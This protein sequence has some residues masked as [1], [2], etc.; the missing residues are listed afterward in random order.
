M[1]LNNNLN[2]NTSNHCELTNIKLKTMKLFKGI[3]LFS[4]LFNVEYLLAQPTIT[5]FLPI[6]G[7]VGDTITISGTNFNSTTANNIVFFGATRAKVTTANTTSLTVTVPIGAMYAPITILDSATGLSANSTQ[8][9]NLTFSPNKGSFG[10]LDVAPHSDFSGGYLLNNID[11]GD[12]NGDGRPDVVCVNINSNLISVLTNTSNSGLVSF[13]T[14]IEFTTSAGPINVKCGDLDGDGKLDLAVVNY[15]T[16]IVSVYR[17]ISSNGIINFATMVNFT[18]G[19]SPRSV[20]I[21]DINGDGKLDLS[22]ANFGSN[23]VSVLRN[24]S[25]IGSISFATKVDFAT[26]SGPYSIA[27]GDIDGNG[28]PDLAVTNDYDSSVSVLRNTSSTTAITF[29]TRVNFATGLYPEFVTV[30]DLNG[31]NK[32]DMAVANCSNSNSVSILR[33]TSSSGTISFAGKVDFTMTSFPNSIGAGDIDGDG[34]PDLAVCGG[35]KVSVIRNTSSNGT[36]SFSTRVD[37]I[38]GSYA[39]S[40]A[41]CDLDGD[42][43]PDLNVGNRN[44]STVAVFRNKPFYPPPTILSYAPAS[45]PVGTIVN[46]TGTLFNPLPAN[47]V[48]FFGATRA[49]VSTATD[50]SLTV[51]VP[52]GATY[53]PITVLNT[54]TNSVAYSTKFFKPTFSPNLGIITTADFAP[55]VD[56]TTELAPKSVVIGDIDGDGMA[57]LITA[58]ENTNTVSILRNTSTNGVV[59]YASKLDFATGLT[60]I[61][62]AIGDLDGDG[63]LD[64]AVLNQNSSFSILRNTSSNGII[65]FAPKVDFATGFSPYSLAIG[66][67]DSDGKP[68]LVV[69]NA[70]PTR[71]SVFLNTCT[72]GSVNFATMVDFGIDSSP[73]SVAIGDLNEDGKPDLAVA[74]AFS[75][76]VSVLRNT[77]SIGTLNFAP[78][79]NYSVGVNPKSIAMGDLNGDGKFDLAIANRNSATV[80]LLRN[81]SSNGNISFAPKEDF[82]TGTNPNQ[83]AIGDMDGNGS[84]DLVIANDGGNSL[85]I[86]QNTTSGVYFSFAPKV[87]FTTGSNPKSVA[88]GDLT[89]DGKPDLVTANYTSNTVSVIRNYPK[90]IPTITSFTPTSGPV[91]TLVSLKGSLFNPTI[92]KNIVFFGATRA[93]VNSATDTSLVVTVPPGASFS[94][95]SELNTDSNLVGFSSGIFNPTYSPNKAMVYPSDF[96]NKL[97]FATGLRPESVVVGDIDGDGKPDMALVNDSSNTVS[98]LLNTGNSG[99]ISFANKLDFVA[100]LSPTSLAIGDIDRDGKLDLAISN[101]DSNTVSIYKNTSNTGAISFATKVDFITGINP[102]SVI[103]GDFDMDGKPDLVVA[104]EGSG[105]V[106]ILRNIGFNG[107][108]SFAEKLDLTVGANPKSLT[109]GDFDKDGRSDLAITNYNSNTISIFRNTGNFGMIGFAPKID[110]TTGSNPISI[111]TGDLDGNGSSELVVTNYNGGNVSV[112]RNTSN[113]DSISFASKM[114]FAT[115]FSPRSVAIGDL[116]GNGKPDLAIANSSSS[117]TVLVN[118]SNNGTINFATKVD[119][120]T[121][122]EPYSVAIGDL[123]VDG[124][125]DLAIANRNSNTVSVLRNNPQPPPSISL[126]YPTNGKVG[127]TISISGINFNNNPAYNIVFFGATRANVLSSNDTS[128]IVRVPL[129]STYAPI[130]VLNTGT[131][132]SAY[133]KQ[134]FNPIFSPNRG[135][136]ATTD[137]DNRVD[138]GTG[139]VPKSVAIGDLDGDGKP[140]LAITNGT[141]NTVSIFRNTGSSGIVS[142]ATKVDFATGLFPESVAIGDING[143]GKPDLLIANGS[144]QSVSVLSNT[145][146]L[147]SISFNAKIDFGGLSGNP[148]RIAVGDLDSD[149]KPDLAITIFHENKVSVLRNIGSSGLVDFAPKVDF[150]TG[151]SPFV[152]NIGDL[153]GDGKPDLAIGNSSE[154]SISLFRN[155]STIGTINFAPRVSYSAGQSPYALAIGDLDVDGK[156]DIAVASFITETVYTFRNTSSGNSFSFTPTVYSVFN[157]NPKAMAIG[158]LNGDGKPEVVITDGGAYVSIMRNASVSGTITLALRVNLGG[159]DLIFGD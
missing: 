93:T 61:S 42:G 68:D 92:S 127:D 81:I 106:S 124:K 78:M 48:V 82:V 85:S 107:I 37:F 22:V 108:I 95:I 77:S 35:D 114:D 145:S 11:V 141:A 126:F 83:V 14:K 28:K 70:S 40:V 157:S 12:L 4:L 131:G 134:F 144:N 153:N 154:G 29:A 151:S 13:A 96:S 138:F 67:M 53:A 150:S 115:G 74:I 10:N 133:S 19:L 137:F 76:K 50:T 54:G 31:D 139:T 140:D 69:V 24:T 158:D 73:S 146:T 89:G 109:L 75:N 123:D 59:S 62:L 51:I 155:I 98:I 27:I 122:L 111:A 55:K 121:G 63:K 47:N 86:L 99:T 110:L 60:Q 18:T 101:Y 36:I 44:S 5:S 56:F 71:V 97:D 102:R 135:N 84:L 91:G 25:S 6:S 58:N 2:K 112:F 118:I 116:D 30:C 66:D 100:G 33:N 26:G 7:K 8:F 120:G 105:N 136:I 113:I 21:G 148:T 39:K 57:D 88:I 143:D 119:F 149:G 65:S 80:S 45:G 104:N 15:N 46:I 72:V 64:L 117:V 23:T 1:A 130:N 90:Y 9:F 3:M 128:L 41:I 142:F 17:N 147:G 34:K 152:V 156:L 125:L 52:A 94:Q 38:S 16:S 129:G 103:I 87:N 79:I 32:L 20:A 159:S 43:K 49:L 132:Y